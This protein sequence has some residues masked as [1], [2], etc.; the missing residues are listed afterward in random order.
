MVNDQD[1]TPDLRVLSDLKQI[2]RIQILLNEYTAL[3]AEI[4][5][6]TGYGFQILV[7]G[8]AILTWFLTATSSSRPWYF[9]FGVAVFVVTFSIANFVN[10]RDLSRAAHRVKELEHEINSR[11]GEHLLVWE[12]LAGVM[13]RMC[14]IQ[15]FFSKVEPRSEEHTSELQSH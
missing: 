7:I 2:D 15:S 6:R 9:W 14:L 13:S 4:V 10:T 11:A 12:T 1:T 3:R 8:T 5:S